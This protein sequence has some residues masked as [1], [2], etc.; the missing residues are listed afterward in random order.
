MR[1][2]TAF[3]SAA[4]LLLCSVG[5]A[6]AATAMHGITRARG[7]TGRKLELSAFPGLIKRHGFVA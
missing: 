7:H 6:S 2:Q 5:T 1:K 3:L 4:A